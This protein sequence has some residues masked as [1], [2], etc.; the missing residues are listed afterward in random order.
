MLRE[1]AWPTVVAMEH[2]HHTDDAAVLADLLDLDAEVL[3]DYLAG[4]TGLL[5]HQAAG[6]PVRRILDLGC[7]T[8]SAALALAGLFGDAQVIAVDQSPAMLARLAA[9]AR[10]RGLANRITTVEADLDE[11]WPAL[12]P[13]DLAWSSMAL[14]HLADPARGLAEIFAATRPGGLLAVA[15][16]ADQVRFLPD[17]LGLGQP[18][19]EGRLHAELG[20]RHADALPYLG[21]DW[22]PLLTS[23]GFAS[24]TEHPFEISL[25]PPLPA[26]ASRYAQLALLRIREQLS[27]TMDAGDLSALDLL[28]RDDGSAS[29][30]VRQDLTIRGDRT[31]WTATRP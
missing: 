9:K 11:A 16:V 30:L 10:D 8:G 13:A 24:V 5:S 6:R 25:T 29:V 23:A 21:A 7:G 20:R 3:H 4:A 2:H 15:E 28:T 31:V 26:G 27:G 19:L 17:D 1:Q 14:H 12:G 22:G 18:G